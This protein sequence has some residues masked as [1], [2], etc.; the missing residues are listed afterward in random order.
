MAKEFGQQ[1]WDILTN[2][3]EAWAVNS[4]ILIE[5]RMIEAKLHETDDKGNP[6]HELEHLLKEPTE[7]EPGEDR[8]AASFRDMNARAFASLGLDFGQGD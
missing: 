7:R 2:S 4:A 5:G 1:P 3:W 8:K 6:L